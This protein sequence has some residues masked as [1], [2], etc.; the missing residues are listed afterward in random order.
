M[1]APK[2]I[3]QRDHY[4]RL[5]YMLQAGQWASTNELPLSRHMLRQMKFTALK[6]VLKMLPQIKRAV[7]KKCHQML[8]AGLTMLQQVENDSRS[9]AE[10]NEV[11]VHKCIRCG[12]KKRYPTGKDRAHRLFAEDQMV[13]VGEESLIRQKNEEKSSTELHKE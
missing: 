13:Q 7:C 1:K 9:Q 8:I 12:W 11:L 6:G 2:S 10:H 5:L 4:A 3:P